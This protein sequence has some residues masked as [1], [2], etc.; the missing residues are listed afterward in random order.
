METFLS[1]LA[2]IGLCGLFFT[3]GFIGGR[4]HISIEMP[5]SKAEKAVRANA[6]RE[7]ERNMEEMN[8]VYGDLDYFSGGRMNGL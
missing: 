1:F 3:I 4:G 6:V 2:I 8:K 5:I 7:L